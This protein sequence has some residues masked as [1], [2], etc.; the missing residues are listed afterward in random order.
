M[1][2]QEGEPDT[3]EHEYVQGASKKLRLAIIV[4]VI[5]IVIGVSA[6]VYLQPTASSG[7][8]IGVVSGKVIEANSAAVNLAVLMSLHNTTDK[9][10]TYYGGIFNLSDNAQQIDSGAFHDNVI[11]APGQTRVLN[12]SIVISLG[13]V[14]NVSNLSSQGTWRLQGT[15]TVKIAGANSTQG[16]D[17]NF[18]TK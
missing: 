5:L 3:E 18:V 10:I 12:E 6:A 13:D 16:F 1:T 17:A 15:A 11:V 9:N 2:R 8:E 7:L 14:V 4:I